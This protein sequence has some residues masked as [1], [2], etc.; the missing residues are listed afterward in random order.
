[1]DTTPAARLGIL[2]PSALALLALASPARAGDPASMCAAAKLKAAA[3]RLVDD[4]RCE[5]TAL[6][7]GA[8]VDPAC[9][10]RAD[11]KLAA[12]FA[13]AEKAGGCLT[14]GDAP[15]A[16][17]IVDDALTALLGALPHT[18][19]TSTSTT[20]STL[21]SA[22]CG[23]GIRETGE[24][25]DG[26]ALCNAACTLTTLAPGCCASTPACID[27]SGWSLDFDMHNYCLVHAGAPNVDGAVCSGGGTCD[28]VA[29]QAVPLCC[30]ASDGTCSP[31]DP[32]NVYSPAST[33]SDL[34]RFFNNC[35][36]ATN[37]ASH[38][39]AGAA[40]QAG[41]HCQPS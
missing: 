14:T 36:G 23:N 5:T 37:R 28:I 34:W 40:C 32:A 35:E 25:C 8:A 38:T 41:G 18:T 10:A 15:G 12:A 1:M 4:V 33:T 39:V 24:Q 17:A 2:V 27:A 22:V 3:H 11:A 9:L 16:G 7:L 30:Q 20:T 26:G 19:T 21:P 31:S 6:R 29:I 13:R